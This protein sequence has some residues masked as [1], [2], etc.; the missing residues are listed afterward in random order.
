MLADLLD[1]GQL[2]PLAF[3]AVPGPFDRS[4]DEYLQQY[5]DFVRQEMVPMIEEK[6]PV[7]GTA[8]RRAVIGVSA[9]GALAIRM[10]L[11]GQDFCM[12]AAHPPQYP[13]P[14]ARTG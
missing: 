8:N 1:A 5:A 6:Y 10:A 7:G 13:H 12:V 4:D 14:L 9:G 3:L 2:S 11:Q